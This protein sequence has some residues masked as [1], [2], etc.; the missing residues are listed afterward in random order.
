MGALL[1]DV[2]A[3]PVPQHVGRTVTIGVQRVADGGLQSD[4]ATVAFVIPPLVFVVT[5]KSTISPAHRQANHR[6]SRLFA[7]NAFSRRP[8]R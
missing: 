4:C 8:T 6:Y 1:Y 2:L 7:T 5:R 3:L